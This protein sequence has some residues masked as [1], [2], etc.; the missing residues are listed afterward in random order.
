MVGGQAR[1]GVVALLGEEG[2]GAI[3]VDDGAGRGAVDKLAG[4]EV[5]PDGRVGREDA[6]GAGGG[7]HQ[8]GGVEDA[9]VQGGIVV[10]REGRRF[11]VEGAQGRRGPVE[12]QMGW[13]GGRGKVH[14]R[15][16]VQV[17]V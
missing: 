15:R 8:D 3:G 12:I 4:G 14:G 11:P 17:P 13:V 16:L 10:K 1:E 6:L 2:V 7:R 9:G 5:L